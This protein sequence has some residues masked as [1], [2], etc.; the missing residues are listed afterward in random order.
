[1]NCKRYWSRLEKLG[2]GIQLGKKRCLV[3]VDGAQSLIMQRELHA[4]TKP[5]PL[6]YQ[7]HTIGGY[8]ASQAD[9][10]GDNLSQ[11][12]WGHHRQQPAGS[13]GHPN[14]DTAHVQLAH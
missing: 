4:G 10:V 1:M 7:W 11:A 2:V 6:L 9:C 13:K 12:N 8:D 14:L 3:N 5:I